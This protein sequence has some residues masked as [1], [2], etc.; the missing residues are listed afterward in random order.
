MSR[1]VREIDS[2]DE[3]ERLYNKYQKKKLII[4]KFW[5]PWCK[6]CKKIAPKI[7][8]L[9]VKHSAKVLIVSVNADN[10][11]CEAIKDTYKVSSL[12]TFIVLKD[13]I[14]IN[15]IVGAD[16]DKLKRVISK[17]TKDDSDNSDE[18]K[19]KSKKKSDKPEKEE[20]VCEKCNKL[21]MEDD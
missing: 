17:N 20:K 8:E 2:P 11:E 18:P 21:K 3:F 9:A 6:P 5:A 15:K 10:E 7:E 16:E 4:V 12:P 19:K 1:K 14:A 13:G